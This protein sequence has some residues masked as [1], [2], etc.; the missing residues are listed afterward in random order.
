MVGVKAAMHDGI[1]SSARSAAAL[2]V[3]LLG[4]RIVMVERWNKNDT[5][6]SLAPPGRVSQKGKPEIFRKAS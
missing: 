4:V 5:C 1:A 3:V 2:L 6:S